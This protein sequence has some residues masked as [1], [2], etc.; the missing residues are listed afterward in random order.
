MHNEAAQRHFAEAVAERSGFG[1]M[2]SE[3]GHVQADRPLSRTLFARLAPSGAETRNRPD[4]AAVSRPTPAAMPH[5]R[6]SAL[7]GIVIGLG[8]VAAYVALD[9]ISLADPSTP[10]GI[11]DR[12]STRLN[13]S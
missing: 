3:S 12:K 9:R 8:Y 7:P 13:S 5:Q 1:P 4:T 11:T 2:T 6:I 10:L